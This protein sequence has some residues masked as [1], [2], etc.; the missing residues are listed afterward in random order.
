MGR[1]SARGWGKSKAGREAYEQAK[2]QG[3]HAHLV[4]PDGT[5]CSTGEHT[6][7]KES[8]RWG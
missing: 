3:V 4:G 8:W 7:R 5:E 2:A 6:T 1:H